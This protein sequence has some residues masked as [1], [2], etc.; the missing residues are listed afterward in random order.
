MKKIM[1][2]TNSDFGLY[3][4]RKE[5]IVELLKHYKVYISVPDGKFIKYFRQIGCTVYC[6][7]IDRRGKNPIKDF[8]LLNHYTK[9]LKKEKPDCVLTYTIKPNIYGGLVCKILKIKYFVNITGLGSALENKSTLSHILF[10]IYK[11]VLDSSEVVFFQNKSNQ[12]KI[13]KS[14][15]N[16]VKQVL[17]PGSGVNLEEYS[18]IN[19][20]KNSGETNYIYVGRIMESKGVNE[21]LEAFKLL[22]NKYVNVSLTFIGNF[23]EDFDKKQFNDLYKKG[24]INYMGIKEDIR[25][26]YKESNVIVNPS[27]HEGMSNVL[28]EAASSGRPMIASNIP[29]CKEIVKNDYNGYLFDTKEVQSLFLA[30]EKFHLLSHEKKLK[31]GKNANNYV[32]KYFNRNIIIDTYLNEIKEK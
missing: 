15:K 13:N 16:S 31:M 8:L 23:E 3:K 26:F 11:N 9:I 10:K 24:I 4:F 25:R 20:P 14:I 27:H 12:I 19:Y 28:L 1:I 17:L 21:L 2:L 29:G 7:P 32:T 22:K 30:L 18:F 5:L 6:T